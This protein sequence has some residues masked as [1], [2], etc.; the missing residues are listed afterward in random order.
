[1]TAGPG[2]TRSGSHAVHRYDLVT[3][4]SDF[5]LDD[6]Y[7]AICKGVLARFA[8]R[9]TVVDVSH[10]VPPQ[11][12]RRA[13]AVLARAVPWFPPAV[14]LAVVDPGVG[15]DRGA[16]A[17]RAGGSVLVGPDNGLLVGAAA[18]LGG[19]DQVVA[20]TDDRWFLHPV[21]ATFHGRDVFAPCAGRLAAG[22]PLSD[23][24]P[25]VDPESLVR[26]PPPRVVTGAGMLSAEVVDVD[27]FGNLQ[28]AAHPEDVDRAGLAGVVELKITVPGGTT[29]ALRTRSYGDVPPGTMV[30][31]VESTGALELAVN[32]GSAAQALGVV[33]G[34]QI[35]LRGA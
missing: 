33:S 4:T 25:D 21:S 34:D 28:L 32:E 20:L 10:G 11:D 16:V 17:L 7:V 26:L 6:A 31:Y 18:A 13:A 35:E 24:G 29:R 30:L 1:M 2:P 14:H 19:A 9:A 23:F 15:T 3:F 8:P 27:T 12:I 22:A 5:G